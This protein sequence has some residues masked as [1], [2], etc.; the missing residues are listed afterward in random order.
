MNF[1]GDR[2]EKTSRKNSF[3]KKSETVDTTIT[4]LDTMDSMDYD[5]T[6]DTIDDYSINSA[7]STS[8]TTRRRTTS[9]TEA[10]KAEPE[11]VNIE[12]KPL[13]D[14]LSRRRN[15][16]SRPKKNWEDPVMV[17]IGMALIHIGIFLILLS[18]DHID[19]QYF[20]S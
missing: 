9:T 5:N 8:S 19:G 17:K 3:R 20:R 12:D 2:G 10:P 13:E 1:Q 7:T 15:K 14:L 18:P 11:V 4:T 6:M 16:N